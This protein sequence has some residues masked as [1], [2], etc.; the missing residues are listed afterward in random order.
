MSESMKIVTYNIRCGWDWDGINSF[1]HR[2]GMLWKTVR[3]ESPDVIAFQEVT[4]KI[5]ELLKDLMPDYLI[6]GQGRNADYNGEGLYTAI[7][8]SSM[9]LLGLETFWLGPEPFTPASK[10]DDKTPCLRICVSTM[11]RHKATNKIMRLYNLHL[12]NVSIKSRVGGI[13][14]V[15][16]CI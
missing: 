8:K 6:V 13:K 2:G 15:L 5:F 4:E 9:D 3:E 7:K 14:C 12:D 10:F 11:V 16:D 1:I